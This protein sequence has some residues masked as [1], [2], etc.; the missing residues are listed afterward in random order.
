[1]RQLIDTAVRELLGPIRTVVREEV[2]QALSPQQ[3]K[4]S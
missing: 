1:M 3:T 4:V 2:S